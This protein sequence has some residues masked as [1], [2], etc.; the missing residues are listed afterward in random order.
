VTKTCRN[1]PQLKLVAIAEDEATREFIAI[2]DFR[3]INGQIRRLE[4]PKSSLRKIGHLKDALDNAGAYLPTND[5]ACRD[6]IRALAK[7]AD[8]AERWKYAPA[9]GWYDGHRV[10]VL[11]D[12]VIGKRRGTVRILP[13][14]HRIDHH[15]FKLN[16]NGSHPDWVTSVAEPAQYSSCMVLGICMALAAPVLDFLRYHS[17]GVLLSGPSKAGKSTAVV[18]AGSVV[19]IGHEED[20]PNFRT[21]D[22]ALGELPATFNDML[23]PINELGLL[24]GSAKDRHQRM[25]DFSYGFAEGRGTTYS[26][27]VSHD[28]ENCIDTWRSL[29]FASGEETMDQIASAAGATR[30][31]GESIRWIDLCGIKR[32]TE[33]IFDRCPKTVSPNDRTKWAAQQFKSLRQ[34]VAD[35]HGVAFPGYTKQVIKS[36]RKIV[37]WLEQ[38]IEEFV[39]WAVDPA[40][41]PAV[42][43]L[44]N[45]FGLIRAAGILGVRFG[46]LPYS[47]KFVDRCIMRCYRAARRALRT[48]T[49]PLRSGLRRLTAKLKSSNVLKVIGKK[50]RTD[51]YKGAEGY[52]DRAGSTSKVTIRA[53]KFKAWF[54]DPRQPALVLRWLQSKKALPSKP[55]PPAKSGNAIVWAESQPEWPDRSRPRSIVI[56]LKDGLLDQI[57]V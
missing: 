49:E 54:D 41:E 9:V 24:K 18:V 31:T 48:E 40:D 52:M 16:R 39:K 55:T 22:P 3:D 45:C 21:T 10:F 13:P 14:R 1:S 57:K 44:A 23:M 25:R 50:A 11:P 43:H 35:N 30:S 17:F 5:N 33:D 6:A 47:E 7:S 15:R 51:K 37:G 34:A 32:G 46:T 28:Y 38:L 4:Q 26:K 42:H 8:K 12:R 56:E 29:G 20:L 53:E 36:R 27:F 19:G 2:I